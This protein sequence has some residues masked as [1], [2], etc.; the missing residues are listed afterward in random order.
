M[1]CTWFLPLLLACG[2]DPPKEESLFPADYA[3][4][5]QEVRNCRNSIEHD[6]MRI[7][8]LASPEALAPYTDRA[9]P[10]PV[11][12]I[13]LKEQYAGGDINCEGPIVQF[14]VMQKLADGE[15][16]AMLDWTWQKT[17][18]ERVVDEDHD[19]EKC[20]SCHTRCGVPEEGGYAGTCAVP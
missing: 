18:G 15:D 14:T 9:A 5:Y 20:S 2:T 11:G 13:V 16:P 8:V 3:A 4:T 6:L 12:A 1:R 19:L 17:D 7:R 10:F